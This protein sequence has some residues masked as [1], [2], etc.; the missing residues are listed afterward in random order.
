MDIKGAAQRYDGMPSLSQAA[1][2]CQCQRIPGNPRNKRDR[3]KNQPE[4]AGL[5]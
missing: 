4:N 3:G 5:L 2:A 1:S